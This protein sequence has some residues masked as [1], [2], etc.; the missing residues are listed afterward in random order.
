[1][2][3]GFMHCPLC[4]EKQ[5]PAELRENHNEADPALFPTSSPSPSLSHWKRYFQDT[6]GIL[7]APPP[8]VPGVLNLFPV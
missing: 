4:W 8:V 2:T 6:L 7:N 1:M 5:A 3:P